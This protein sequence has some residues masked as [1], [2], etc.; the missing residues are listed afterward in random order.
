[1]ANGPS[2]PSTE[3]MAHNLELMGHTHGIDTSLLQP[4]A[5]HF[6]RLAKAKGWLINQSNEYDVLSLSSQ[7]P[8]GMM[9]TLRAHLA[10]HNMSEREYEVLREVATVRRELGSPVMATPL[11][12]L[13]GIQAV[14]N[15]VSGKRYSI[16]PD[17]VIQYASGFYG[18]PVA[19]IEPDVLDKIMAA[20][21]AKDIQAN[22]PEQPTL[23]E[24][25]RRFGTDDDELLLRALV[26]EA[27]LQR[28]RA[29]GPLQRDFPLLSSPE[30]DEAARLMRVAKSPVVQ[31]RSAEMTLRLQ[32]GPVQG[33]G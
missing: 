23:A 7:I 27:D 2:V 15:V 24:L 25:R 3:I 33:A 9:G 19:P 13:V 20:P 30:L 5:D 21:R 4:V 32:R 17:E 8:G 12:Q 22:R 14:L 1:M 28:M 18:P 26:P 16:I 11:S 31:L 6:E 29:A 10:Q